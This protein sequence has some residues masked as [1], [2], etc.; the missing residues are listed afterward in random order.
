MKGHFIKNASQ[1]MTVRTSW[2]TA[3]QGL[4][5]SR[6]G[7]LPGTPWL[8]RWPGVGDIGEVKCLCFSS[9]LSS[10]SVAPKFLREEVKYGI[11]H[12]STTQPRIYTNA[13]T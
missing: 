10:G 5:P 11:K 13:I 1:Q 7:A 12:C 9:G 6:S 3:P 2:L 8:V 4:V